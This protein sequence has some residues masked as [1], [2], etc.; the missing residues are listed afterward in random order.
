MRRHCPIRLPWQM[1]VRGEVGKSVIRVLLADRAAL[2]RRALA[3]VLAKEEDLRIVAE[4]GAAHEVVPAAIRERPEAVV[5]YRGLSDN[6]PLADICAGLQQ[7]VPE[8]GIL[9][10]LDPAAMGCADA[11]LAR[12]VPRIGLIGIGA[13]PAHL[14]RSVRRVVQREAVLDPELAV[15]ALTTQRNPLTDRESEILSLAAAGVP[16]PEIAAQVYLSA[17]TVR[18][19][20]SRVVTKTGARTRIEAIRIAQKAG[21]I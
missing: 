16:T 14:V 21:W 10:V 9:V 19:Y 15:V 6:L 20:L 4:V 3:E 1:A 13:S 8:C 11:A 17:G 2:S 12:H 5:L 7:A 18:N